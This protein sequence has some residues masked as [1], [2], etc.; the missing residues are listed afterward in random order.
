MLSNSTLPDCP[1]DPRVFASI[2][3]MGLNGCCGIFAIELSKAKN[4]A[5]VGF[6]D[7]D[8]SIC[9]FACQT[10]DGEIVDAQGRGGLLADIEVAYV[11]EGQLRL[12]LFDISDVEEMIEASPSLGSM[13]PPGYRE[14]I[15][16]LFRSTWW[17]FWEEFGAGAFKLSTPPPTRDRAC[18]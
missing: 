15:Q 3:E 5:L 11:H 4:Y 7:S 10:K 13:N 14:S 16:E 6:V 8:N 18:N 9:H 2:I 17:D 12:E 1:F